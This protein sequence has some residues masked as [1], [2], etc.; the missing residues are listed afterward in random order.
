M[1]IKELILKRHLIGIIFLALAIQGCIPKYQGDTIFHKSEAVDKALLEKNYTLVA[2]KQKADIGNFWILYVPINLQMPSEEAE[3]EHTL[4]NKLLQRFDADL[5][6]NV[7]FESSWLVTLY[8]NQF[9]R[10]ITADV[11]KKKD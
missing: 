5:L 10:H 3:I 9:K 4:A 7:K 8:W 1:L 2:Q 11:W 6:T